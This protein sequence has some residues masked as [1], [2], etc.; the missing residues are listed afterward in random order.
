MFAS[1]AADGGGCFWWT[2]G[3][4]FILYGFVGELWVS[5]SG[6]WF[7]VVLV[8]GASW[9][10]VMVLGCFYGSF[11]GVSWMG[12][13]GWSVSWWF[14]TEP[15][16]FRGGFS[17]VGWRNSGGRSEFVF[18]F[19]SLDGWWVS[20]ATIDKTFVFASSSSVI[21]FGLEDSWS[22]DLVARVG[23]TRWWLVMLGCELEC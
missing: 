10:F 4:C 16:W 3:L 6:G 17:G 8:S 14:V 22:S 12:C 18:G 23:N 13:G 7:S 5:S 2:W 19:K 9:R 15:G 20:L 21:A 11:S 1:P